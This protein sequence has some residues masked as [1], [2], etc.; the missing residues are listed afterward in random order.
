MF[1]R[2]LLTLRGCFL[3]NSFDN[4]LFFILL[5]QND[6][7]K[8]MKLAPILFVFASAVYTY[9]GPIPPPPS[10]PPPPGLPID[11]AVIFVLALG[12]LYGAIKHFNIIKSK[13]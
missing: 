12:L 2:C 5:H 1:C 3:H 8:K 4:W 7:K 9:Q 11:G 10:G 13:A 6:S